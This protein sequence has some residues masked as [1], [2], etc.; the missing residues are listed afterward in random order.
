M[1]IRNA[2]LHLRDVLIIAQ[3]G[4][5][6]HRRY[7]PLSIQISWM[8]S[9]DKRGWHKDLEEQGE[10]IATY[11]ARGSG[12]VLIERLPKE[13]ADLGPVLTREQVV[14]QFYGIFDA[15]RYKVKHAVHAST[16][17]RIGLTY[18]Y[19]EI[20]RDAIYRRPVK[21]EEPAAKRRR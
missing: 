12:Q 2:I 17:G 21:S 11:T 19:C 14:G 18:R 13:A 20:S 10:Y 16:Q 9:N 5:Q 8:P 4:S 6:W 15:S 1:N 7:R 3:Y